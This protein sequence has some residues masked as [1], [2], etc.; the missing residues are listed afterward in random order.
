MIWDFRRWL[1][2]N[3]SVKFFFAVATFLVGILTI[4]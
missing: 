3:D 4:R 1:D 2:D